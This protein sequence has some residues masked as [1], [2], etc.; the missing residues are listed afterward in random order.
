[1]NILLP[2]REATIK[3]EAARETEC[4]AINSI[5]DLSHDY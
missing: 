3:G 2:T 1:M 4:E 5:N